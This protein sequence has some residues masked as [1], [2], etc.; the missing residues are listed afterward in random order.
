[1]YR[2]V[3]ELYIIHNALKMATSIPIF[4]NSGLTEETKQINETYF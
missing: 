2:D 1:M 4:L 3:P